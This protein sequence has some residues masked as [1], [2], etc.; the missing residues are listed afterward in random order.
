[1]FFRGVVSI[2][3][4]YSS[5]SLYWKCGGNM[6]WY[7]YEEFTM[8]INQIPPETVVNKAKVKQNKLNPCA[9]PMAHRKCE[10]YVY[11]IMTFM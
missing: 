8:K 11:V 10:G 6:R 1:M 3:Y 2:D 5:V 4:Q 7:Q 9:Y